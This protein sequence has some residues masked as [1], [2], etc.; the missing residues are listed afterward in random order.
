[1]NRSSIR[2]AGFALLCCI[3]GVGCS[4]GTTAPVNKKTAGE[5]ETKTELVRLEKAALPQLVKLPAQLA[6][7]EAVNIFPKVNGY[8]K[9][10]FVDV[11]SHVRKGQLLMQLEAPELEQA[12][13]QARERYARAK[14][15]YT[16]SN[17]NYD[18]M[19]RAAET[20][21][22]VSPMGLASLK[23]KADADSTLCNAEKANWQMQQAILGYLKVMAPFDGVI[24]ERN[25]HPGA[26]VNAESKD[27][28]MLDL[29]QVD[30]LRLQVDIPE[31][32]AAGLQDKDTVTFYLSAYP[33][34][35]MTGFISRRSNLV[36][37][38]FRAE[39]MELD[40]NNKGGGLSPGMYADVLFNSK[41]NPDAFIV[42]RTAVV[43]S[44]ER[45]YVVVVRAG[46]TQ[47]VDVAT[48]NES[49]GKVEVTG[50]LR[51]GEEIVAHANDELQEGLT[52]K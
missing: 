9:D 13:A 33:G 44:T 4:D 29:R 50:D 12:A 36:N 2:T 27:K 16:I 20:P 10:V 41:G 3:V 52:I 5:G 15:D 24:A 8:V 30:R 32:I 34:K 45:K 46:R 28:P 25:V 49:A 6:S 1:M 7:Y 39:R 47:R 40:V 38:Q 23:A 48:G 43:T 31:G 11:G 17:E 22:A 26:L 18:R 21:G 51:A 19:R 37:S 42:P 14:L 35:K